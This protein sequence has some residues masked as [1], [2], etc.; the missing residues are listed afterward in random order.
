MCQIIPDPPAGVD[1]TP[2]PLDL[3]K[4]TRE[5]FEAHTSDKT[6]ASCHQFMD[7]IGF[8]FENYDGAGAFRTVEAGRLIDNSG[9]LAGL[10]S[11]A[12]PAVYQFF[13]VSGLKDTISTSETISNCF[14]E[15][16]ERFGTGINEVSRCEVESTAKRWEESGYSFRALW[17]EMV[18]SNLYLLRR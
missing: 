10:K 11:L 12:D 17:L 14:V 9:E 6:C 5:R 7:P 18:S 8:A 3:S 16:F 15:Q 4:P 1:V 13:G 2:V